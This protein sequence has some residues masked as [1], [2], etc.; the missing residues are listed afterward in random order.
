MIP[1]LV[2]LTLTATAVI[3]AQGGVGAPSG[4]AAALQQ[5]ADKL[6]LDEKTQIPT[7]ERIFTN[8]ARAATSVGQDVARAR[9]QLLD[10]RLTDDA[11]GTEAARAALLAASARMTSIET[12]AY[13]EVYDQLKPNQQSRTSQAFPFMAGLFQ[14]PPPRP[15]LPS[16]GRGGE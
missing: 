9:R 13:L 1:R 14:P 4:Q 2:V 6:K 16:R 11:A 3:S 10:A 7:V 5:I 15:A 12:A 8:A